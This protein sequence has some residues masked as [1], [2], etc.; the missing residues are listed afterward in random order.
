MSALRTVTGVIDRRL[1]VNYRVEPVVIAELLP[2]PFRPQIVAG[3]AVAGIC[4]IR[5]S[6]IRPVHTP[7]WI[8]WKSENAAQGGWE[9]QTTWR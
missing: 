2:E 6:Q 4:L 7:A 1:L 5:L 9:K 8:G 3:H